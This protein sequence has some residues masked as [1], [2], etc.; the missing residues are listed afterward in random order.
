MV[1]E[2]EIDEDE[3][4]RTMYDDPQCDF[5]AT[6]NDGTWIAVGL[7]DAG[8]SE[9]SDA[10]EDVGIQDA[11]YKALLNRY[12]NLRE[13]LANADRNELAA[14]VKADPDKYTNVRLPHKKKRWLEIF[15]TTYPTPTLAAQMWDNNLYNALEF[16]I[17]SLDRYDTISKQK[18]CWIWTLL[19]LAGDRG[20]LDYYRIGR[21]RELALKAGQLGAR[22]R[23]GIVID[24]TE[25]EDEVEQWIPEGEGVDDE[26]AQD[27]AQEE[28][29]APGDL[30]PEVSAGTPAEDAEVGTVP[31]NEETS[32]DISLDTNEKRSAGLKREGISERDFAITPQTTTQDAGDESSDEGEILEDEDISP[33]PSAEAKDV[34]AAR[35]RLL[36]QLG[37]RLVK[38]S[39][40][41]PAPG[42]RKHGGPR[43][44]SKHH[45]EQVKNTR[46]ERSDTPLPT[47][48]LSRAEAEKQRQKVR[49]E[50]PEPSG[51]KV[52]PSRAEAEKQRQKLREEELTRK[53][54]QQ[55]KQNSRLRP[56]T[57]TRREQVSSE[58]TNPATK[59]KLEQTRS[60]N[61]PQEMD[62]D[63]NS[64]SDAEMWNA[65]PVVDLNTRVTID[66]LL[67]VV[68][69]CYGQ[70][71][72]LRYRE[73][74]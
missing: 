25:S 17:E 16:C 43:P 23:R 68:A 49:E 47:K 60:E 58:D 55:N 59:A 46:A 56:A 48:V 67:T 71:D 45:E 42:Y 53:Q 54:Q 66:V 24:H 37:E 2:P 32:L 57:V 36:A 5:R 63:S 3:E 65:A 28:T 69:E 35:A 14:L 11:Y 19:A 29:S 13:T 30:K 9:E 1:A 31:T 51:K 62:L 39:V 8:N 61:N 26:D 73:V 40:P 20:T 34:E 4:D 22:L 12:N 21:L 74:W 6:Y 27:G 38:P 10:A 70:R 41:P 72:L 33:K 50:E 44:V 64:D 15:E 18:S 7:D 52:F